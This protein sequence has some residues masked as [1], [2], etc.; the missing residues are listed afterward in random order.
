MRTAYYILIIFI[1]LIACN[2]KNYTEDDRALIESTEREGY[3]FTGEC[4]TPPGLRDT[5]LIGYTDRTKGIFHKKELKLKHLKIKGFEF[6]KAS[7]D[8]WKSKLMLYEFNFSND[9]ELHRFIEFQ[10]LVLT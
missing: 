5:L 9:E 2:N 6:E 4:E 8:I 10:N 3:R 1:A 7:N